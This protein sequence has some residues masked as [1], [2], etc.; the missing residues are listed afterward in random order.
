MS[1]SSAYAKNSKG[2]T[3]IEIMIAI[4]LGLLLTVGI[5]AL[6]SS[7]SRVNRAEEGLARLQENGRYAI[8]RVIDDLRM[9][10]GQY[11]SNSGG[12]AQPNTYVLQ[13]TR[14]APTVFVNGLTLPDMTGT[15][16]PPTGWPANTPY[17]LSPRYFIQGYECTSGTCTPAAPATFPAIGVAVNNRARGSDLLTIRGIRSNGWSLRANGSQQVCAGANL[18]QLTVNTMPAQAAAPPLPAVPADPPLNFVAGDRAML[19]DCSGSE[20]ISV[21]VGGTATSGTFTPVGNFND[22]TVGCV[23]ISSDTRLFNF[24]RDFQTVSYYLR[25]TAN[26]DP[27][28]LGRLAPS[29]VRSVNG[30]A[31]QVIVDGV[32]RLDFRYGVEDVNGATFFLTANQ[33]DGNTLGLTCPPPPVGFDSGGPVDTACLW[34]SIKSIEV[35]MLLNT[36]NSFDVSADEEKFF[37][38]PI[39]DTVAQTPAAATLPTTLPMGHMMRREFRAL[40]AIRNYSP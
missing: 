39:S 4:T 12:L 11:C 3:L 40:V 31:P 5:M 18:V 26:A 38:S 6:F 27:D 2:F 15:P 19:S 30:G 37:Y 7:V 25:V 17:P 36:V 34:R 28:D 33:V 10:N 21:N 32:D 16:T 23:G 20:I 8:T 14:R 1:Q 35:S 22:T 29:L 9:A 13:D 24:S